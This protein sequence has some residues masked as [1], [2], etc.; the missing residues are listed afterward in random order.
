MCQVKLRSSIWID[1]YLT[2]M[3]QMPGSIIWTHSQTTHMATSGG[4]LLSSMVSPA[5]I[6]SLVGPDVLGHNKISPIQRP[7]TITAYLTASKTP[8]AATSTPGAPA[9]AAS[10]QTT[11]P[12]T[13]AKRARPDTEDQDTQDTQGSSVTKQKTT[14]ALTAKQTTKQQREFCLTIQC[15]YRLIVC[16]PLRCGER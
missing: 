1:G 15:V 7:N 12:S 13:Q 10:R 16:L 6:L 4:S 2:K 14:N 8:Q 3:I 9:A 11:T 5:S